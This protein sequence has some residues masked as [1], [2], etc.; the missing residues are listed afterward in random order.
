M[1]TKGQLGSTSVVTREVTR[2]DAVCKEIL[3]SRV[4][5]AALCY[6]LGNKCVVDYVVQEYAEL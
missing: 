3:L 4:Q 6:R 2:L 1:H 5:S